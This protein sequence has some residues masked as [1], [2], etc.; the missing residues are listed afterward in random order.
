MNENFFKNIFPRTIINENFFKNVKIFKN[1]FSRATRN[2]DL[3]KVDVDF[4]KYSSK[5]FNKGGVF[6]TMSPKT[7]INRFFLEIF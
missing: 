3:L 5:D 1:I 2:M 7:K 4:L 6:K